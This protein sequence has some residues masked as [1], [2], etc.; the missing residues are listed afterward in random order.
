MC[1]WGAC[2]LAVILNAAMLS[3]LLTG[4]IKNSL[5]LSGLILGLLYQLLTAGAGGIFVFAGGMLLPFAVTFPLFAFGA[6]GAGDVKLLAVTGGFLGAEAMPGCLL[7]SLLFGAVGAL[8]KMLFKGSLCRRFLYLA[9]YVGQVLGEGKWRPYGQ[10]F[11]EEEAVIHLS[12]CILFAAL[13]CM[14]GGIL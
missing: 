13:A 8:L 7:W 4:R 5:I 3:D 9:E 11:R 2:I 14:I 12:V 1:I 10:S 6:I